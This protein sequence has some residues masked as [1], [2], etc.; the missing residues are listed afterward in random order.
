MIEK[1]IKDSIKMYQKRHRTDKN[2]SII[3]NSNKVIKGI[4]LLKSMIDND[5]FKIL[6]EHYVNSSN[7]ID[8]SWINDIEEYI[9][10]ATEA[11]TYY[12]NEKMIMN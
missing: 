2:R 8:S 9:E 7:N 5:E 6:G 1:I 11:D 10:T 4:E 3:S 12:I